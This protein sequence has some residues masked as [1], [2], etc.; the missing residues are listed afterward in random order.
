MFAHP[1]LD[2][3]RDR[4]HGG[5]DVD[6]AAGVARRLDRFADLGAEASAG[7]A[8]GAHAVNRAIEMPGKARDQRIGFAAPAE[9]RHVHALA[10]MLVDQHA[11]VHA[12]LQRAPRMGAARSLG[13]SSPMLTDRN[14][15][16]ASAT[17]PR[18]GR[19]YTT[20]AGMS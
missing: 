5:L 19:R 6:P 15:M 3:R 12:L 16:I 2:H 9:E 7:E 20:A 14:G 1:A 8:D 18:F 17:A 10:E 11:D 13:I 4:L